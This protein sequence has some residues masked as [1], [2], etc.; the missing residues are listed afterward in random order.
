MG[1]TKYQINGQISDK[2]ASK[3]AV[4]K[5]VLSIHIPVHIW[6]PAGYPAIMIK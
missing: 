4:D 6:Y 3:L 5:T 2:E 1:G